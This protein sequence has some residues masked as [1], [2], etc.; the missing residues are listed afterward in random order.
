MLVFDDD[1]SIRNMLWHYFDSRGYEVFTFP[2]PQSCPI[3]EIASCICPLDESC[4]DLIISDLNMPFVKGIEFLENQLSKGCK[5]QN[6][7]LMSGDLTPDD[8]Q[9]AESLGIKLF[10]KPFGLKEIDQWVNDAEKAVPPTRKLAN[11]FL[12]GR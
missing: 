11:W 5:V 7:A 2:H 8:Q 9:R 6:L 1:E 12:K 4:S 10:K 3:C